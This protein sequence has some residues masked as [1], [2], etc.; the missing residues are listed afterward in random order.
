M[1]KP[2]AIYIHFPFC[3]KKCLYCDFLSF[4]ACQKTDIY[5]DALITELLTVPAA[6]F[7][8]NNYIITSIFIGGGTPSLM[9]PAQLTRLMD[10][11]SQYPISKAAEITMEANPGTL[12]PELL[13]TMHTSGI[14]RL[15]I[16]LQSADDAALSLLG[17]IHTYEQFEENYHA[18][19][20][21]GFQNINIDLMSALP[22]QSPEAYEN[23]LF[24]IL[25]LHPEHISAYSLIIEE[26]TPFYDYYEEN[27]DIGIKLPPLPSEDD[28]RLMYHRTKAILKAAGYERY[29]I[30]NYAKKGFECRHNT[31]YWTRQDYLGLGL[32]AA[33][34][35]GNVRFSNTSDFDTYI[36]QFSAGNKG[37][38]ATSLPSVQNAGSRPD[39]CK[40]FHINKE[41]LPVNAQMEEFMFLGLRLTCGVSPET[42]KQLFKKDIFDIYGSVID[43]HMKDGTL[44]FKAD[45]GC[46]ALSEHG[47][48]VSN[49]IMADFILD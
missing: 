32:G 36:R 31:A 8:N 42:F 1:Q 34:M 45:S 29:E 46:I 11:L 25:S 4:P 37:D 40:D 22:G 19:R 33:S 13:H 48:D 12:T 49:M 21:A 26:G 35:V 9:Q 14:N 41:N 30:S 47:L 23:G 5:M 7:F 44:I 39:E 2:I 16:G 43:R 28:E 18:A 6:L 38:C 10:V 3:Q 20:A 15:S 24:R 27:K 17:R